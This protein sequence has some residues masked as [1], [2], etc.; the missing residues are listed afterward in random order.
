MNNNNQQIHL[1]ELQQDRREFKPSTPTLLQNNHSF[2]L[3]PVKAE[4]IHEE[5]AGIFPNLAHVLPQAIKAVPVT[6][7]VSDPI[8]IGV[9][10]SGG[11]A[12]GGHNVICGLFDYIKTKNLKSRLIGFIGGP[13]GVMT[14][15]WIEITRENLFPYRNQGGFDIIT[16]GRDKIETPEQFDQAYNVCAEL[17]LDGLVVVGGDD[18][19]TNAALL[20]EYFRAR[21]LKTNVVGC[22]KTIDGDLKNEHVQISF[23]FD[24]ACKVYS[25][26]IGN[27]MS[28]ARSSKKY[29]HFVR[30]MGRSASHIAL[31]CALVTHPN[32]TLIGEEIAAKHMTLA[33]ITH[34]LCDVISE[35]ATH[36]FNFGVVL[37][38]EGLIE[39]IPE[40]SVL[41]REL[42]DLLAQNIAQ[43]EISARL[44]ENSRKLFEFLPAEI[45]NQ[46]LLERD[47]HGNVQVSRIET[48][49]LLIQLAQTELQQRAREGKY[50]GAFNA[51]SHFFGYEGRCA[52][53]S[54]F[55][56]NYCYC[57]G[58]AAAI[59]L[60]NK[61]TGLMAVIRNLHLPVE[62][63][64][65]GGYPLFRMMNIEQRKGKKKPVIKKALVELDKAPFRTFVEY[66]PRWAVEN[67]YTNPGPIQ[68]YGTTA[69]CITQTLLLENGAPFHYTT[70][71]RVLAKL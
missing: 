23:G 59:L 11:P 54:N 62:S 12:A 64:T 29:Y 10:L 51:M 5:L 69:D 21:K 45:R 53:P 37:V 13:K 49:K 40:V 36:G 43:S 41:I 14:G 55:D 42:N 52:L 25:E 66:R 17:G 47:P 46:L 67:H 50:S 3:E 58:K 68:F 57:L 38:P 8:K 70:A 26:L 63:W 31:E 20:A 35:R 39:F 34:Q 56:S 33:E 32:F 18:S 19:N 24:T 7:Y 9:V 30:L 15:K 28:D 22:P 2:T 27:I 71:T 61:A 4:P 6:S 44:T 48:E 16:T 1:S 65:P 60:E